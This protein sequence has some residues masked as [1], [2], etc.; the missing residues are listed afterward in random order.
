MRLAEV[1]SDSEA[2]AAA[3]AEA[4]GI[5]GAE[6]DPMREDEMEEEEEATSGQMGVMEGDLEAADEQDVDDGLRLMESPRL[7]IPFGE[8]VNC[9]TT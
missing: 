9:R 2:A 5:S 6:T 7:T 8:V 4:E 1:V 3:A